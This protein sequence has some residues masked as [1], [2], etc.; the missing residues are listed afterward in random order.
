PVAQGALVD[1]QITGDLSDRSSGLQDHLDGLGL[2][3]SAEFP[4]LAGHGL[5]LSSEPIRCPRSLI[6]LILYSEL[7]KVNVEKADA[8]SFELHITL[9]FR[10]ASGV[11]WQ[12]NGRGELIEMTE[13][14]SA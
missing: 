3:L 4:A 14:A 6:H 1:L 12:R 10:D 7:P 11:S 2:E 8:D 13:E 5:I 9:Q